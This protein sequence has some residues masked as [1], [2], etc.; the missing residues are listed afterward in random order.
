[1]NTDGGF[2]EYIRVPKDWII[3]PNPFDKAPVTDKDIA[4]PSFTSMVYGTAGLTAG[5]CIEKLLTVGNAKP[6]DGPIAITGASGGVGSIAVE[7]LAQKLGFE[8]V[9][10][11][12]SMA[13]SG[14]ESKAKALIE[15]G[16]AGVVERDTLAPSNK[17]L[18]KPTYAHAIDTV[19]GAP[20]AELFKRIKPGGSIAACGNAAGLLMG[21]SASVLPFIL[22]GIQL[23]GVDSVE[24]SL[25]EK[26]HVWNKLSN[27]WRC[28]QAEANCQIIGRNDLGESLSAMLEGNSSGVGRIVL[29]H[30]KD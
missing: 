17:P 1:M 8:V 14:S 22:K 18:L 3:S 28:G 11:S 5:L 10:I 30:N 26:Q 15:L 19:G 20:L 12:G 25:E 23:L 27:E 13:D 4:G 21:D 7:I 24:I 29:D 16:A 9:A 6:E 2:G